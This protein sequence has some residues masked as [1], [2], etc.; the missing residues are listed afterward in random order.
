MTPPPG[1]GSGVGSADASFRRRGRATPRRS[2]RR[3]ASRR[4]R[5]VRA[6]RTRCGRDRCRACRLRTRAA[7][8][9]D[10]A[11]VGSR[12]SSTAFRRSAI[13][14][15]A[16]RLS[17]TASWGGNES[18]P[19]DRGGS[20]RRLNSSPCTT[21]SASSAGLQR[22]EQDDCRP[23][24]G[25]EIPETSRECVQQEFERHPLVR[26]VRRADLVVPGLAVVEHR[27]SSSDI[28]RLH[29]SHDRRDQLL[30]DGEPGGHA[31]S[32][33]RTRDRGRYRFPQERAVH[34]EVRRSRHL[35]HVRGVF[36]AARHQP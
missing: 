23:C 17:S 24:H 6:R 33:T 13:P 10:G 30:V 18:G 9:G 14:R 16:S 22:V 20:S 26:A 35:A 21:R 1:Y 2:S 27:P 32:R 19:G 34:R 25:T 12:Y 8:L 15:A 29:D 4:R 7:D 5:A 31:R 3:G 28:A 36:E 11:R